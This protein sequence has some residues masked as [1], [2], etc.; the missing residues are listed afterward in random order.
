LKRKPVDYG[1]QNCQLRFGS[2]CLWSTEN[3]VKLANQRVK[4]FKDQLFVARAYYSSI[5]KLK[6]QAKLSQ[7]MKQT[8]QEYERAFT[9][10]STDREL[11]PL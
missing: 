4:R 11:P 6:S 7:E 1:E 2:Y 9:E 5:A 8:I 3:R 10:V